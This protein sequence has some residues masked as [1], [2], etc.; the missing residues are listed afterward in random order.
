MKI[1]MV[2]IFRILDYVLQNPWLDKNRRKKALAA[3]QEQRN[4]LK[5]FSEKNKKK[6]FVI[7]VACNTS[8]S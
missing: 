5:L 4:E 3:H 1:E 6:I 8:A 7:C 2:P